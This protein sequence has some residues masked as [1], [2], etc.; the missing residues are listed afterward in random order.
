MDSS[1]S[2]QALEALI[3]SDSIRD[4]EVVPARPRARFEREPLRPVALPEPAPVA[5][6]LED[7]GAADTTRDSWRRRLL[8]AGDV[9]GLVAA[10]FSMWLLAPPPGSLVDRLPLAAMP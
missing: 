9:A 2:R 7:H 5:E 4:I 10:Y 3:V 6:L 8:A 1:T